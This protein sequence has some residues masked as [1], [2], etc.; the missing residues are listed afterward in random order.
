MTAPVAQAA[1]DRPERCRSC[2]APLIWARHERTLTWAPLNADPTEDGTA[3][4]TD[5]GD[6]QLTYKLLTSAAARF[7][8]T[9]LCVPHFAVCAQASAWRSRGRR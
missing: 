5:R 3:A 7:G 4:V 8:R 2:D 1:E 9:G 6:G